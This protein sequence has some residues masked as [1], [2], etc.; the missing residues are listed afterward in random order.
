MEPDLIRQ[1]PWVLPEEREIFL[2]EANGHVVNSS[3][4]SRKCEQPWDPRMDPA[5]RKKMRTQL[6]SFMERY[7]ANQLTEPAAGFS[8][9]AFSETLVSHTW[10]VA[11]EEPGAQDPKE[12][13]LDF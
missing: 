4:L 6:Y 2:L 11:W 9:Q 12:P 13:C 3:N 7:L 1:K 5:N 10:I 8:H